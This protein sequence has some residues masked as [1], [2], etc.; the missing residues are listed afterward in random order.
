MNLALTA[1]LYLAFG[2]LAAAWLAATRRFPEGILARVLAVVFWPAYL[3]LCVARAAPPPAPAGAGAAPPPDGVALALVAMRA[4]L[5][6]LPVDP[7]RRGAYRA[8]VDRL[9]AA[10]T[11]RRLQRDRLDAS[12]ARLRALGDRLAEAERAPLADELER[13]AAARAHMDAEIARARDG[14][15]RLAARL[16]LFEARAARGSLADELASLHDELDRL[17]RAHEEV[18]AIAPA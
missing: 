7:A 12:V 4:R 16:E 2:L 8:A 18:D 11:A 5:E 15:V 13:V 6:E 17:L 10:L 3:P 14:V 1:A 9:E